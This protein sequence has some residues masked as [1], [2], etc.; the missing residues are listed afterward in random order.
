MPQISSFYGIVI[1]MYFLDHGPPH[2]HAERAEHAAK[3]AISSG[4]I[5]EG[6]LPGRDARLLR[7]WARLHRVELEENWAR[8]RS[9]ATLV[10]IDPLP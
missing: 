2:F 7:R 1:T 3:V 6:A 8:A 4:E 9:H 10:S 5:Y